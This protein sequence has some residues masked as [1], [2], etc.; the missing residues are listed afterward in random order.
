M[1]P[2]VDAVARATRPG[3][4]GY[5]AHYDAIA[6]AP[7]SRS[8]PREARAAG[9]R[10]RTG[11]DGPVSAQQWVH[12]TCLSIS[13]HP[14]CTMRPSVVK[15][16]HLKKRI[17]PGVFSMTRTTSGRSARLVRDDVQGCPSVASRRWCTNIEGQQKVLPTRTGDVACRAT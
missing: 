13:I 17:C 10:P 6:V 9:V 2:A 5:G 7:T 11:R 15:W 12:L 14:Q 8:V 16:V 4:R 1:L 3:G